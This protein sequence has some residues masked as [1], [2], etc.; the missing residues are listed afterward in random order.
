MA[1]S[2]PSALHLRTDIAGEMK[3]ACCIAEE[4]A[5]PKF[6]NI[7]LFKK[8]DEVKELLTDNTEKLGR[9]RGKNEEEIDSFCIQG[10]QRRKRQQ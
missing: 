10:D 4:R 9:E 5:L 2:V 1:A 3:Q 6:E 8:N 7:F